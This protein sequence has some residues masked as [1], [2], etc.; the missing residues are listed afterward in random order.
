MKR[1]YKSRTDVKIA[2]VCGGIARY[3]NVDPTVV[4]VIGVASCF[5]GWGIVAYIV[6]AVIMPVEPAGGEYAEMEREQDPNQY[7]N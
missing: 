7:H 6:C 2:G 3:L 5:M 4:R 1:L